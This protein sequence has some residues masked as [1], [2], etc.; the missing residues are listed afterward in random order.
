M[1]FDI[2]GL[3]VIAEADNPREPRVMASMETVTL[4][5]PDKLLAPRDTPRD[6][7]G[8][9]ALIERVYL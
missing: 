2:P 6:P 3:P 8:R 9:S 5:T 4:S 7:P 1:A